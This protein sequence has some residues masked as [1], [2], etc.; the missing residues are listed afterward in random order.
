[1]RPR[2][3]SLARFVATAVLIQISVLCPLFAQVTAQITGSI[4]DASGALVPSAKIT[5][6]NEQTDIAVEAHSNQSGSYLV[7]LLPPGTYRI[8]VEAQGFK[9]VER[10][11]VQLSVAESA[12]LDLSL[13][14]GGSTQSV[15]VTDTTPLLDTSSNAIGGVVSPEKVED[16]P[17]LGRNS[18]ALMTLVPGV[19]ATRA[20][21]AN[22]VLESHYQFFSINGSRPNQSQFMFDGG[23]NT[24]L[25]FNGPE[26]SPQVEEVQEF[27]IQTSNFSAEY[28]STGGGVI[29]V[30]S[31]SGANSVHGSLF[32]YF[33]NDVLSA[34]D[35]FSNS[36][37]KA[38]PMLRYNQFGGTI[39]GPIIKNRTFFFFAYEGLREEVPTVVTTSVPTALQ[40]AGDFSQTY[41]STGQL[42]QIFDPTTT[43]ANPAL[44]G[45]Y[46]RSQFPG[47]RIPASQIDPVAA[48]IESYYPSPT[49]A[50]NAYTGLNNYL[51][52]GPSTRQ[53]DDFSGRVDHQLNS[54]TSLMGRFSRADLTN[55]TNPATF[56]SSNIA[57]PGYV[58]KPQHHPYALGKITKTFSPTLFGEALFSWAR[59]YYVS[60]GLSNGFDPTTLGF[61]SYLAKN[62]L[63]LGFPSISPGE[64]S[65]LGTYYN[66]H[67]VS[68]R[69]EGKVNITKLAG[70]HTLKF[71]GMYGLGRYSTKV[72]DNS[73]GAY[74]ST[75]AFTQGPN[76]LVSSTT[77]GFGFASFLLGTMSSGTQNVTDINGQYTAP[78]YGAY[79]QDD[80]KITQRLTVNLGLRWEFES[81]R[82]EA[83][84]QV[85]NF[86]YADTAKLSN[87]ATVRG[88]LLFPGVN[89]V[90]RDNW[91]PNWK[92]FAPRFGFAYN[93]SHSTVMRGGY[94]IF[95]S[96]S[97]GNG[98]NNNAMPQM[99][100]VCSTSA[101]TSLD[102]GLTPAVRLS[103]PFPNGFC[104]ATGSSA[105]LATNLGQQLYILDRNAPQPYVQSWNFDIQRSLPGDA[106]VEVAYSGSHGVH[107]MGILERDQLSPQYFQ[108]GNQL[109]SQVANPFYGAITQGQLATPTIT[110]GQSLLPY[111]QFLGVSSRNANYGDSS[112]N[113]LLARAERRL[114]NGFSLAIAYTFSKEIDDVV[115]SVN[116]FPGESFAGGGLQNYY[117]LHQERALASW[118]TPQTLVISYVYELPFGHGKP[119]LNRGGVVD[120]VFGGWQINGN[121]TFQSGPPLQITGG[122]ASGSFAGTQ[123][124]NWNGQNPTLSGSVTGRLLQ[125]F[126]TSDFSF[127]APFTFGNAPRLM[128]DLRGPGT[129][130]FDISLFKNIRILERYQ[131]Q[132]RAESFNAFNRVQFGNPNT[133]INSTAFGVISSQQ[134]SPRNIQVALRLLF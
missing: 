107:L 35:F 124:P 13:E 88:G 33:R 119:F 122:N 128:P 32:E 103:N 81:P 75:A 85:S 5:V 20:T 18:N 133:S 51:F 72:N 104:N 4:H 43:R 69:Y 112:Y 96:N 46:I 55:W 36:A 91:N 3:S 10:A 45:T 74:T 57:S 8:T 48:K 71:G 105:G 120:K 89:G 114:S 44:P 86:D 132:F 64:M 67:D 1:M 54:S 100:F 131:L 97:W 58:T 56:G 125:Y 110:L 80:Y 102:N 87:G 109:N 68:D 7:P 19:R 117:D 66:E 12:Q 37:G 52:S 126:N 14:V 59:W 41:S 49:S 83:Q 82:V 29:N 31:K 84:N 77:S 134:N 50:G 2:S 42:V 127:N 93:L 62:S 17:M 38:R 106:I 78:Y 70:K 111:P 121:T 16:L 9:T 79:I 92:D 60:F 123:R 63:T 73:T 76:P 6:R 65:G 101:V 53:T 40:R 11:G 24:N 22:P 15:T 47:N 27:R 115:P 61:P 129:D 118:D 113:A 116:G 94:G 23:N 98:R 26:Y 34:N 28:T 25:T 108:L 95:Y 90:S 99:G 130:D 30:A 21:T 39:G